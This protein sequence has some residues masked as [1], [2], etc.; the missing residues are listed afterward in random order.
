[1]AREDVREHLATGAAE[2]RYCPLCTA[3]AVLR[4]DRP[5]VTGK[6]AEAGTAFL[7]ALRAAFEA[8]PPG[9]PPASRVTPIDLD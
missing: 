7:S 1:L 2:C 9:D 6:L 5:E 8:P 4:G 3:I